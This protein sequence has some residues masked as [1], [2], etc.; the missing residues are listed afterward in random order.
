MA[1]TG[2]EFRI[3]RDLR[4]E[5][6]IPPNPSVLEFGEANWYGDV[7]VN[8]L[9]RGIKRY[10]TDLAEQRFLIDELERL[11]RII[12]AG[13]FTDELFDIA[14]IFYR[15]FLDCSEIAAID[16]QG[17]KN[18]IRRD[19]NS[20]LKLGREFDIALNFGTGEHVFN[21]YQFFKSVH[22]VTRAGGLMIHGMPFHGWI[23]HGFY[24][25]QPTFYWDLATANHYEPLQVYICEITPT[26]LIQM[27]AREDVGK[28][29]RENRI[30]KNAMIY[31][32]THAGGQV[33]IPAANAGL[34]RGHRL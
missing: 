13:S 16:L 32:V 25:F 18:A 20:P 1:I 19:L 10:V 22:D 28:L 4:S 17:T 23:D 29:V 31:A 34:L 12:D 27:S 11:V 6:A 7:A 26:K 5:G 3:L 14:K 15:I 30:A 8:Q 33:G 9:V 21:T 24:C 2:I